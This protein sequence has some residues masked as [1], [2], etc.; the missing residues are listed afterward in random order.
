MPYNPAPDLPDFERM[1]ESASMEVSFARA[2]NLRLWLWTAECGRMNDT[3]KITLI[4]RPGIRAEA[5]FIRARIWLR[6]LELPSAIFK[7]LGDSGVDDRGHLHS[8]PSS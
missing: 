3:P 6:L 1:S 7:R 5:L 4:G 2:H 8:P